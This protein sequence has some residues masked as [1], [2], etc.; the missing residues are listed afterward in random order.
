M[1]TLIETK[2]IIIK[3]FIDG[4]WRP[5]ITGT[6]S[7]NINPGD[8]SCVLGYY[9]ES[10]EEDVARAIESAQRAFPKWKKAPSPF[11]GR[12]LR[13]AIDIME[14]RKEELA[15]IMTLEQGKCPVEAIGEVAKS[16]NILEFMMG[17]GRRLCGETI[18]SE[19]PDNFCY[20]KRE[21]LG[22]VACITPW[23]FPVAIPIWKLTAALISGNTVIFKPSSLTPWSA[24]FIVEIF[25][26]AGIPAGVLNMVTGSGEIVG[27]SLA[28]SPQIAA[29]SFTGSTKTGTKLSAIAGQRMAKIQLEMGGKNPL[30][31]LDDADLDM[32]VKAAVLGGFGATGQRCTATSRI[33]VQRGVAKKFTEKLVKETHKLH[34]G[35]S[36]DSKNYIGPLV[37]Q[38]QLDKVLYYM[39]LAVKEGALILTGGEAIKDSTLSKG[40]YV[41]PTLYGN[42]TPSMTIAQEEIFGPVMAIIEAK[43]LEDALMIANNSPYGLSSSI[44]TKNVEKVFRYIDDIEVGIVH[45]NSATI[46]GEAQ[47]PFGGI[48]AS[49][50]GGREQGKTA[51]DFFT[52]WKTVY[53]DYTGGARKGSFY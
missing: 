51:I 7:P 31:I 15:R 32:A 24:A 16:I 26:D 42:V 39:D 2:Q 52:E 22:V 46:G 20:T 49:G 40:Y 30:I 19:L 47:A 27:R 25:Q 45:I 8:T 29:I 53:I 23:N 35:P 9:Q 11:R 5:A 50:M 38:P 37:S 28:S 41:Q 13:K 4:T 12:I 17:E 18:P 48:K 36:S 21:P 1:S 6:T 33:I 3:N 14:D 34:I 10:G 43:D 44:Y